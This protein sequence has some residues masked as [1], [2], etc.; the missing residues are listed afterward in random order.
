MAPQRLIEAIRSGPSSDNELCMES[1]FLEREPAVRNG[2][3]M[4]KGSVALW[5][6]CADIG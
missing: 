2:R 5:D 3:V 6:F 1:A 4:I